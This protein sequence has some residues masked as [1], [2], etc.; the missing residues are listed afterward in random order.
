[1]KIRRWVQQRWV[2]PLP[3]YRM[4][5]LAYGLWR[6]IKSATPTPPRDG[7]RSISTREVTT[8]P[9]ARRPFSI[10]AENSTRA[11]ELGRFIQTQQ[12]RKIPPAA[13]PRCT[14]TAAA[15]KTLLSAL[16]HYQTTSAVQTML[17]WDVVPESISP[18]AATTS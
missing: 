6:L 7:R 12:A 13:T 2:R 8:P 5:H 11:T 3:A 14:T 16:T 15:V 10:T 9:P 4:R 1:M 17:P 18:P